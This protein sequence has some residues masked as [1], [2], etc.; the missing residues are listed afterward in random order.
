[1]RNPPA[2]LGYPPPGTGVPPGWDLGTSRK[3][4]GTRDRGKDWG[5]P[6]PAR[7]WNQRPGKKPGTGVPPW[8]GQTDACENITF[9]SCYVRG[10]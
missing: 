7:T 8:C 5:T 9:P 3:L 4:P 10:K 1:M 6:P 2:G